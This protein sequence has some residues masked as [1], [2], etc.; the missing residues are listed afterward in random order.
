MIAR[1]VKT[2]KKK[3]PQ[4]K[5]EFTSIKTGRCSA[6]GVLRDSQGNAFSIEI[7]G[8]DRKE[9]EKFIR[10][11]KRQAEQGKGIKVKVEP[12]E[13]AIPYASL[14]SQKTPKKVTKQVNWN[15][16]CIKIKELRV[17]VKKPYKLHLE[18][19]PKLKAIDPP[20]DYPF[21]NQPSAEVKLEVSFGIA[22]MELF[23][24]TDPLKTQSAAVILKTGDPQFDA[25]NHTSFAVSSGQP[26]S[27]TCPGNF[28]RN[29]NCRITPG[30]TG[31]TFTLGL[32]LFV[33]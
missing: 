22:T 15:G 10:Y 8:T 16:T 19:D 18:I 2:P 30:P 25:I 11:E 17:K 24:F 12:Y 3:K 23:E 4:K 32:D 1:S 7:K 21:D 5:L 31:A 20:H 28:T 29:W 26:M 13:G 27:F 6:Y 9:V 33:T 14:V